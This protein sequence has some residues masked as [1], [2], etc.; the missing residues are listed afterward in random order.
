MSNARD[1]T[2]EFQ[3]PKCARRLKASSQ[4]AGKRLKCP[5][6]GQPVKVPGGPTQAASD[7]QWLELDAPSP[8]STPQPSPAARPSTA[9]SSTP[10]SNAS[11]SGAAPSG[12]STGAR[13]SADDAPGEG[14]KPPASTAGA[15]T[16]SIFDDDLPELAELEAPRPRSD[17]NVLLG[18]EALDALLS[19]GA[20]QPSSSKP[21]GAKPSS[22]QPGAPATGAVRGQSAQAGGKPA[23]AKAKEGSKKAAILDPAQQQYRVPCPACGTPQ[24]VT[25]AMKGRTVRCPD[26]FLEFKIPP[27]P[28]GWKPSDKPAHTNWSTALAEAAP[29]DAA[30]DSARS[31]AQADDYLRR[32]EQE[33]A[34]EDIDTLY[35]GDF[36]TK[37]F[38][39]RTFGFCL[40]TA[41]LFQ[42]VL[43][44]AMF[45]VFFGV[46]QWGAIKIAEGDK[47][48]TLIVGIGLPLMFI[49][50]SFPMFA[51]AMTLLESVANG[52][53]K[54]DEWPG[55]SFFDHIGE[56]MLFAVALAAAAAPGF[57]LGGFIGR[58]GGMAWMVILGTMFTTFLAFPIILLS[59]LDNE[60]LFNPVSPDV[61][62]SLS[63]GYEAWAAYYFK[64]FAAYTFVFIAWCILF[65][66]YPVLTAIAGGMLPWLIFFTAQ[67]LGVLAMDISEQLALPLGDD[68]KAP[69]GSDDSDGPISHKHSL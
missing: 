13:S 19:P 51:A 34:D 36:D 62:R 26:C 38:V 55:F 66:R 69:A 4:A 1:N 16:P 29:E 61:W 59:M 37:S 7:D 63:S 57:F 52:Q 9:S 10:S 60:S 27:P 5:G 35:Q 39:R 56:L 58:S 50:V 23:A 15:R 3:C 20:G 28:P 64:T 67:Q 42:V 14:A 22:S 47:G 31:R 53:S 65:G 17:L 46:A 25:V 24:Y 68:E 21:G 33:L 48:V 43:Y 49:I 2:L 12:T 32:A 6:C 18:S 11:S 54:V 41:A 45:A 40:D 44:S 30:R 8:P